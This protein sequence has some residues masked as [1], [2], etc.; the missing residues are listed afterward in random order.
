MLTELLFVDLKV[1]KRISTGRVCNKKLRACGDSTTAS[2][3]ITKEVPIL[4][5]INQKDVF[6]LLKNVGVRNNIVRLIQGVEKYFVLLDDV[7]LHSYKNSIVNVVFKKVYPNDIVIVNVPIKVIGL[8]ECVGVQGGGF[9]E[10]LID[11]VQVRCHVASIPRYL[12]IN[13]T[14]L[15]VGESVYLKDLPVVDGFEVKVLKDFI[16]R[17]ILKI[18]EMRKKVEDVASGPQGGVKAT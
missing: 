13:I 16:N 5:S 3:S 10:K 9:L 8:K 18:V 17:P 4:L 12:H 6:I 1:K 7:Q 2:I 11:Q 14:S 15:K